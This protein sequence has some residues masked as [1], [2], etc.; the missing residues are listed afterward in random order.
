MDAGSLFQ[1]I[2]RGTPANKVDD[3]RRALGY[4]NKRDLVRQAY[5]LTVRCHVRVGILREFFITTGTVPPPDVDII[6]C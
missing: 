1:R 2:F 6:G 3:G 4:S 5:D